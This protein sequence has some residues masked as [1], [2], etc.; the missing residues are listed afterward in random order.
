MKTDNGFSRSVLCLPVVCVWHFRRRFYCRSLLCAF[1]CFLGAFLMYV[2]TYND[3][4]NEHNW[5][6]VPRTWPFGVSRPLIVLFA[7][8]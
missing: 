5:G 2:R 1:A 6:S 8:M 4:Y 7:H 3:T